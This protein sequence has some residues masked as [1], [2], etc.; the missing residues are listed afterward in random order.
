[1]G[2]DTVG[3]HREA[4]AAYRWLF[5]RQRDDGTWASAYMRGD[6]S[7]PTFDANFC[8][9]PTVGCWFHFMQTGDERWL[10]RAW[11]VIEP[12]LDAVLDLQMSSGAIAWAR[13]P[14]GRIW[15]EAL[16]ASSSSI[17]HS[18]RCGVTIAEHLGCDRPDWELSLASLEAS[19][20]E[21]S[22][23]FMDKDR[24]SMDHYYPA[25]SGVLQRD[26]ALANLDDAWARFVVEGAGCRCT[27][28]RPWVTS[29]ETCE[30]AIAE[31]VAGRSD[32]AEALFEWVQHLRDDD[33]MYWTGANHPGGEVWPNEKT[34][35]SAGAVLLAADALSGGPTL[36]L[37]SGSALASKP[38][39]EVRD[40]GERA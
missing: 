37:F 39:I 31:A 29:G 12:A 21:G 40:A 35:W 24:F 1:M 4:R 32:R 3:F 34:T 23:P 7:D 17:F 22:G 27:D 26:E 20:A 6:I 38:M 8:A 10:R 30:L 13:D 36:A 28:D 15:P 9:Y 14:D 2:L 18:L 5:D 25:L 16:V 11:R 19:V 33:G